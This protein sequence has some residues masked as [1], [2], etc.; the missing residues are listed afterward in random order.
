MQVSGHLA[1]T[2]KVNEPG[3]EDRLEHPVVVVID[4]D[5]QQVQLKLQRGLRRA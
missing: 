1:S 2:Y 4:V 5:G 3:F